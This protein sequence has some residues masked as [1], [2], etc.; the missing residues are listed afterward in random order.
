MLSA[1][2]ITL[3]IRRVNDPEKLA[4]RWSGGSGTS[5]HLAA[6]AQI[7]GLR[8]GGHNNKE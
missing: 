1:M 6:V 7:G 8:A 5:R 3:E 2:K 4:R